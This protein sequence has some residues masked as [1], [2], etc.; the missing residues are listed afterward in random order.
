MAACDSDS[1]ADRLTDRLADSLA[2]EARS[3]DVVINASKG[4]RDP[5][6]TC[7]ICFSA[8]SLPHADRAVV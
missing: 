1:L 5:R 6:D 8:W 4:G 3:Y 2:D 7:M